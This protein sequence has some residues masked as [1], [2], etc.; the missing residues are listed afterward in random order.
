MK[1]SV[2]EKTKQESGRIDL[3]LNKFEK[4]IENYDD[5]CKDPLAFMNKKKVGK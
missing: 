2:L 3:S 4:S 5:F 1:K